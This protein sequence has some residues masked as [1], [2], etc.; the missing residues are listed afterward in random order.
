MKR[1]FSFLFA[2]ILFLASNNLFS[3]VTTIPAG[4]GPYANLAAAFTAIN[5]GGVYSGV[6]VTV[7]INA[8]DP[9][10]VT[11]TLGPTATFT[12][13]LIR[14]QGGARTLTGNLGEALIVL[15][16]A[17]NV[18]IDGLNSGGN[19]LTLNN[20]STSIFAGSIRLS[21][22]S[23]NNT[24]KN[25][26]CIGIGVTTTQG[27]RT[28]N[29]AQSTGPGN[30]NN[31]IENNVINGG[32]RGIQTFGSAS[33][34][35]NDG[36]IIRNNIV[37][38]TSSLAIFIGSETRDNTVDNN[39]VFTD[40]PPVVGPATNF[41]GINCQG[42]G[43]NTITR[44][45]IHDLTSTDP[46]STY[47]G[48]LIIPVLLTAPGSNVTTIN[49]INNCVTLMTN[50]EAGF[51]VGVDVSNIDNEYTGNIYHNTIRMAGASSGS[52]AGQFTA[53]LLVD[54]I[55]ANSTLNIYNNIA[56]NG[57]TGGD[58]TSLHIG[59]D[60]TIYSDSL[61]TA[62]NITLSSDY[63]M[64]KGID[65]AA[66]DAG[67]DGTIFRNDGG[68]EL[69][70]D[71]TV[72]L[73][74]EQRTAFREV[75]FSG[76]N[77][78]VLLAGSVGGDMNG[79]TGLV[80]AVTTDLFGTSRSA[81]Y[82]YKGAYEGSALKVLSLT[83]N[84]EGKSS[85]Q[86]K[87]NLLNAACGLVS[88]CISDLNGSNQG[89]F[90]FGDAVADG[91]G[92]RLHVTQYN[93]IETFSALANVTFTGGAASYDF[94]S[95]PSQAFGGNMTAGPPSA[96]FGGDVNQDSTIDLSDIVLIFN[97]AG[98]FVSGPRIRT[99]VNSDQ[100]VD[101]SDLVLAFNNSS[102]FVSVIS[103][104]PEPRPVAGT[105]IENTNQTRIK[106]QIERRVFNTASTGF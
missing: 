87:L 92:Y 19:S 57:R 95:S 101:L 71:V 12:S 14:P 16:N 64:A 50:N 45:R 2:A 40:V 43:T 73:L 74:N 61:L 96:F 69:Y 97:D 77:S 49:L 7:N 56:M 29:I 86:I 20:T 42:V 54:N 23:S 66:W 8:D 105:R 102:N 44:N 32:R 80:P 55:Q 103:P 81:N 60:L 13:C 76:A 5:A 41:R 53:A 52:L 63:Q 17:D 82:P 90:V 22:G 9:A 72:P 39:E 104:C 1:L 21:N 89:T 25:L 67:Y 18:T 30:N 68:L 37:K 88:E 94:T 85:G 33:V 38:N 98:L 24:I 35:T 34:S 11:A 78:C 46:T 84:L 28:I 31:I 15:D 36:T 6:A 79:K 93:H 106:K 100:F 65:A 70:K 75:S 10:M 91:V 51:T 99:D 59:Y 58:P 3:Q 47:F 48:I 4:S 26:T 27:G 83:A 62:D